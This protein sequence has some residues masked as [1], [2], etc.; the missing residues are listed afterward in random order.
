MKI[1]PL[2]EAQ[3][4]INQVQGKKDTDGHARQQHE[5]QK[6]KKEPEIAETM[7]ASPDTV[8]AAIQAFQIDKDT[9]GSGISAEMDGRG[10][11]LRVVLKDGSG[12]IIRQFTGE[13]FLKLREAVQQDGRVR[14]KIL[15]QKL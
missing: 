6:K 10:P 2:I 9:Q 3:R 12:A 11:G 1:A 14:G 13:E 5:Q 15:D 8:S 4:F 7:D